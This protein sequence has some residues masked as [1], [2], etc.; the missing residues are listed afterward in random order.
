MTSRPLRASNSGWDRTHSLG[1][2][3]NGSRY[4]ARVSWR[5]QIVSVFVLTVLAAL[6]VAGA[7]CALVCDA[8]PSSASHHRAG[9]E[10]E[11]PS[12]SAGVKIAGVTQD[13]CGDHDGVRQSQPTVTATR[14]D[15]SFSTSATMLADVPVQYIDVPLLR[16]ESAYSPPPGVAPSTSTPLV[17]RV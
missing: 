10:C 16:A 3:W 13:P 5:Q 7:A 4:T 1:R 11:K 14:A 6:P 8:E 15:A 17:L 12:D 2:F 9:A